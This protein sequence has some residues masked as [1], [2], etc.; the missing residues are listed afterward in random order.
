MDDIGNSNLLRTMNTR[1]VIHALKEERRAT[2]QRLAQLTGLSSVTVGTALEHLLQTGEALPDN[3][4]PSNG[5]RPAQSYR[6]NAAY[7]YGLAL[8]IRVC[9]LM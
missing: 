7:R 6:F 5:G 8:Y 1:A 2:K 9:S 3:I 4:V